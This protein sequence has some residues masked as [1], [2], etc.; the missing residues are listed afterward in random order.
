MR[1][2]FAPITCWARST[3][4]WATNRK[5]QPSTRHRWRWLRVLLPPAR[6]SPA[7]SKDPGTRLLKLHPNPVLLRRRAAR[8]S[9]LAL[10]VLFA[11]SVATAAPPEEPLR[12]RQA[13]DLALQHSGT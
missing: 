5:P 1:R 9:L 7:C 6:R 13:I 8:L 4:R 10:V 3:R 2:H 11:S 12:F